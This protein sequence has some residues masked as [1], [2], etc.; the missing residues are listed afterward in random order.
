MKNKISVI[1]VNYKVKKYLFNC[2]DSLNKST[3][4]NIE[5]IVVDNDETRKLE[6]DLIKKFPKIKYLKPLTNIG[7][8]KGNNLGAVSAV[9]EYL[10]F[11]NP[12]TEVNAKVIEKLVKFFTKN[13]KAGIVA[14]LLND[15]DGNIYDLQGSRRYTPKSALIT[16]T[17]LKKINKKSFAKFWYQEW[18]KILVKE[19]DV[20]PG[21]AFMIKREF[22]E[23]IKGFDEDFFLFFEENQICK[24]VQEA[25]YKNYM[26][27]DARVKHYWGEST[28]QNPDTEKVFKKSRFLYFRK[29]YG[30]LRAALVIASLNFGR[31]QL[32]IS[33][34]ILTS[35]IL[36]LYKVNDQIRFIGDQAWFYIS[37]R[38]M[39]LT[40]NIPLVGITSS[41]TWLH[42]GAYW[43]YI[44]AIILKITNF[45]PIT[46]FYFVGIL[47]SITVYLV[48]KFGSMIFTPRIGLIAAFLYASSP[49]IVIHN[50]MSY[51]TTPIPFFTLLFL[52]T[53]YKWLKGNV[54]Y[55]PIS[56]FLLAVLYN[57][58]LATFGLI[59]TFGFVFFVG[60]LRKQKWAR[61]V[62]NAKIISYSVVAFLI[63]MIPMILYDLSHG[64]PQTI[65]F[66][67]WIFYRLAVFLGYPPLNPQIGGETWHTFYNYNSILA[68][69]IIFYPNLPVSFIIL[70]ASFLYLIYLVIMKYRDKKERLK[71]LFIFIF[72][73]LPFAGFLSQKT[74]SEAYL[75]IFF[76]TA[77]LIIAIFFDS[78]IKSKIS[79]FIVCL[80]LLLIGFVNI[81]ALFK[82]NFI[83]DISF[84]DRVN[85]AKYMIRE[86]NGRPYNIIGS[87]PGSEHRSFI[88]NHE[89][90]TWYLGHP[91]SEKKEKLQFIIHEEPYIIDIKEK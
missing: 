12:D 87:G 51:H 22:F 85:A 30:L 86:A 46:G 16:G 72:F 20:V 79:L 83:T 90:L 88:M 36:N 43:T 57:L 62:L 6:K 3:Y 37:A 29:N 69:D 49:L 77:M 58:E 38:D 7:Y 32:I 33:S 74:N 45:N 64:F 73:S 24:K 39:L 78:F 9:G 17:I 28:K 42:Q 1:I 8:G 23:K 26:L 48:Y 21:T 65:K 84:K 47:G 59:A 52:F 89:Y 5:I 40:G 70:I 44:L 31:N 4:K 56:I 11:I 34:I 50:R 10:F 25:G 14:P 76:P 82:T 81:K 55:F 66:G 63:P 15:S 2:I 91:P 60:L 71:Y 61:E 13:K 53:A 27:P 67:I 75:L 19:V 80:I 54:L 18:D 35:L 41:H 68:K